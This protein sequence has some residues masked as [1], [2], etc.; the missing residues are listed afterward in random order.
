MTQKR[1]D[2]IELTQ[3]GD[4]SSSFDMSSTPF[5][6]KVEIEGLEREVIATEPVATVR[7]EQA[8]GVPNVSVE[9]KASDK[10][11]VVEQL[12]EQLKD[13]LEAELEGELQFKKTRER[14]HNANRIFCRGVICI[15]SLAFIGYLASIGFNE[16]R[17][18]LCIVLCVAGVGLI[19]VELLFR[20]WPTLRG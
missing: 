10:Q 18:S 4:N 7:V 12:K 20:R 14:A 3:S 1:F 17:R 2:H 5:Q 11:R 16:H 9:D 8:A 6:R 15:V 19:M 13:Q